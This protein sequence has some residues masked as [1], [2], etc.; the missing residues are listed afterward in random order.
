MRTAF[1]LVAFVAA[2][3]VCGCAAATPFKGPGY[4]RREG[5]TLVTD[6]PLVVALT[7][8]RLKPDRNDRQLFWREVRAVEASLAN[9]PGLVGYSLRTRILGSDVWT[10]TIWTDE[11]SLDAFVRGDA[12]GRA[13]SQS[14]R[15]LEL[16]RFARL[17][18]GPAEVPLPWDRA[19]E[20][21]D[22]E[23]RPYR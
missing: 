11:K 16:V 21:L 7:E 3:A 15:A 9:Q 1:R 18:L 12:H 17:R 20:I 8:A 23:G 4:D 6:R 13:I 22:E 10:M 2:L 19:I 5:V 14:D